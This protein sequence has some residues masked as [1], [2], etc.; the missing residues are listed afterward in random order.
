M[1]LGGQ[2]KNQR[3]SSKL[4][5]ND[6]RDK[7]GL[8]SVQTICNWEKNTSSPSIDMLTKM[9]ELLGFEFIF[10]FSNVK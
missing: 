10:K 9:H 6:L 1:D 4:S 8:K 5:Q 2:I 7:L 3:I